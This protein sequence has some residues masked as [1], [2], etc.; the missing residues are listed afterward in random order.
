VAEPV[1]LDEAHELAYE[2]IYEH[3]PF[4]DW[5]MTFDR[6]RHRAGMCDFA[7]G[8]IYLSIPF[9]QRYSRWEVEQVMLHE[10][11]HAL[12]G[13]GKDH[14]SEW[15]KAAKALGY[16]G[17]AT[18]KDLPAPETP[19]WKVAALALV[20]AFW[21]GHAF[22]PALGWTAAGVILAVVVTILWR[23]YGPIPARFLPPRINNNRSRS[24]R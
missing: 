7:S 9:V 4:S 18:V 22:H 10:I 6:A 8:T 19:M 13:P 12:V 21:L 16:E 23:S 3:L 5:V 17:K 2:L 14:G 1:N 24:R 20:I 15:R 11:A